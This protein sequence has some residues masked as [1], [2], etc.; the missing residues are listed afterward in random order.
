MYS[1]LVIKGRP[2]GSLHTGRGLQ[3]L[4]NRKPITLH[5]TGNPSSGYGAIAATS[6]TFLCS[7]SMQ[8]GL[9]LIYARQH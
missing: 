9:M 8:T 1:E 4:Q 3:K 6:A 5:A 2:F 7:L